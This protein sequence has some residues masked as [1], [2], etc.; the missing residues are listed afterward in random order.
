MPGNI[1]PSAE[2]TLGSS[3]PHYFVQQAISRGTMLKAWHH[4]RTFCRRFSGNWS[5]TLGP[6][7]HSVW[8]VPGL[9]V[10]EGPPADPWGAAEVIRLCNFQM[11]SWC[12]CFKSW[13][14]CFGRIWD[15]ATI[16][17]GGLLKPDAGCSWITQIRWSIQL[18]NRQWIVSLIDMELSVLTAF[19]ADMFSTQSV[20]GKAN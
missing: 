11:V 1:Y 15:G 12:E 18:F 3:F 20:W 2:R 6:P 4:R 10:S 17:F 16:S 13:S 19:D 14:H 9:F 7:T 5:Q 8:G